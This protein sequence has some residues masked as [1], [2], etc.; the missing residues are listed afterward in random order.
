M[1]DQKYAAKIVLISTADVQNFIRKNLTGDKTKGAD[2]CRINELI[3]S[4]D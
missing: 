2:T 3:G 1:T 4:S